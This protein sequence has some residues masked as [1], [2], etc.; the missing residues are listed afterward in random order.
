MA[1]LREALVR[2][3]TVPPRLRRV[4]TI[5]GLTLAGL[6]SA[7]WIAG[8]LFA[9]YVAGQA[10]HVTTLGGLTPPAA[11]RACPGT[12]DAACASAAASK[13]GLPVAWLPPPDGY[14]T[15]WLVAVATQRM[16][17]NQFL[18]Y[19][20]LISDR[21]SLELETKPSLL[22]HAQ[23]RLITT[24]VI[25]G[26]D[27]QAFEPADDEM[28]SK[29][30]HLIWTHEGTKYSLTAFNVYFLD[31]TALDPRAYAQ[32]VASVRYAE[33]NPQGSPSPSGGA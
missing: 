2:R 1:T 32:L 20:D 23:E 22:F 18:A 19:E 21:V 6:L 25:N 13:I 31:E 28:V 7:A 9:A 24:F 26:M 16:R 12:V 17:P 8:E 27:V 29:P 4:L 30:I 15:Q 14:R 5:A 11:D 10:Q 33:P 3:R